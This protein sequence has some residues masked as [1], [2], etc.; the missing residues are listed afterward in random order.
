[1]ANENWFDSVFDKVSSTFKTVLDYDL[2]KRTASTQ[3]QPTSP[4]Y[5]AANRWHRPSRSRKRQS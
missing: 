1:M 2:A 4:A 5:V 3:Q